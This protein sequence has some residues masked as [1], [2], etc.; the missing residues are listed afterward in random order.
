[1]AQTEARNGAIV[2]TSIVDIGHRQGY[3]PGVAQ[4]DGGVFAQHGWSNIVNDRHGTLTSA[5]IT[6]LVRASE[7]NGIGSQICTAET[8]GRNAE[9]GQG[10]IVDASVVDISGGD[11][12]QS[13]RSQ[14]YA[15]IFADHGRWNQIDNRYH[16]AASGSIPV[17]VIYGEYHGVWSQIGAS[18]GIWKYGHLIDGS[19]VVASTLENIGSGDAGRT[20]RIECRTE[21]FA[22]NHGS[23]NILQGDGKAAE[24]GISIAIIRG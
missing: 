19:A 13:I 8:I 22:N 15:G 4:V 24:L 11:A 21:G 16:S 10:A 23:C 1:M 18:E 6:T 3:L 5:G 12:G 9:G 17:S 2:K 20:S 14:V 7:D